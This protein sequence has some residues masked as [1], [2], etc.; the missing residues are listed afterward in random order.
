MGALDAFQ[1]GMA[2]AVQLGVNVIAT[3]YGGNTDFCTG[4]LPTP[5]AYG[6]LWGEPDLELR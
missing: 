3:A 5:C 4:P 6:H 1:Q 2:E